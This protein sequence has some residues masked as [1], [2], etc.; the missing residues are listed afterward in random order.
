MADVELID[1]ISPR[2]RKK[3][4]EIKQKEK[5]EPIG[6]TGLVLDERSVNRL[7]REI[8]DLVPDGWDVD[9]TPHVTLKL[10]PIKPEDE[11][12]IKLQGWGLPIFATHIGM[13][14]RAMAV[15]VDIKDVSSK[16]ENPH[17]TIAYNGAN[18]AKP[19]DSNTITNWK[20]LRRKIMLKGYLKE[21]PAFNREGFN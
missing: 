2:E 16:N 8:G 10:G 1:E 14:D 19:K 5:K 21:V 3:E 20:P 15:A 11:D 6:Y 7:N 9:K 17:I 12:L 13:N 18:G 4:I